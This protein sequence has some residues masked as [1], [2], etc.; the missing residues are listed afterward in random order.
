MPLYKF[1]PND[2][3]HNT[4]KTHPKCEF[5]ITSGN[6]YY[7][8]RSA[9]TGSHVTNVGHVPTGSINLYELNID[10]VSG[11]SGFLIYPFV[12]LFSSNPDKHTIPSNAK[13]EI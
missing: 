8:T 11:S 10:R 2:I 7:T 5:F 12:L 9:I 3:F 13:P 4:I 6:V 1:K